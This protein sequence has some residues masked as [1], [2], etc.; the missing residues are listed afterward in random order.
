VPLMA[1]VLFGGWLLVHAWLPNPLTHL[2][3]IT[4]HRAD[5]GGPAASPPPIV[6]LGKFDALHRGHRALAAAA[7]ALGGSPV[8]LSFSGMA[9]VLGW[10][11][12]LPL[13]P[14]C[15]RSRVLSLWAHDLGFVEQQQH[16]QE[17][18]TQQQRLVRQR[19]IPFICIRHL[20]PEEFVRLLAEELKAAGVVAGVN[21]RFGE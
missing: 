3:V 19:Y 12:R 16:T 2:S 10:P 11:Q 6:A 5:H 20:S 9:E 17:Q 4:P 14:P 8:L 7:A 21:Y 13:V 18:H 1:V 15:D